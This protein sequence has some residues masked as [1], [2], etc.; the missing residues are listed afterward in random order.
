MKYEA[1]KMRIVVFSADSVMVA[2]A[3]E[4]TA[5]TVDGIVGSDTIN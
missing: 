2:S 3:V 4:T 5:T 1:P